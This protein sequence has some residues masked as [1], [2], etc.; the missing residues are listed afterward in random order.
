MRAIYCFCEEMND[1]TKQPILIAYLQQIGEGLIQMITENI[2]NPIGALALETLGIVLSID[3]KF[4][5]DIESKISPLSI[6]I[7]LKHANDPVINS[8]VID[9]F[10]ILI[11]NTHTNQKIEQRLVP[12]LTSILNAPSTKDLSG[13]LTVS[14]LDFLALVKLK[15][16]L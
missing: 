10:K 9:I 16:V 3:E 11:S 14:F 7:F 4:V 12:T 8:I 1:E 6:A 5:V 2:S 13:L 15:N